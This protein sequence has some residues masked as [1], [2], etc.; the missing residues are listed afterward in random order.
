[1]YF[2]AAGVPSGQPH[3]YPKLEFFIERNILNKN[4][5]QSDM[6][7][8]KVHRNKA[9]A[10]VPFIFFQTESDLPKEV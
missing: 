6:K 8:W 7:T 10:S 5:E 9:G 3:I 4:K 1:M 2:V